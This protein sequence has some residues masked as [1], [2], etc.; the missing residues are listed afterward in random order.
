MLK[1]VARVIWEFWVFAMRRSLFVVLGFGS[2]TSLTAWLAI[3]A[4]LAG[5]KGIPEVVAR[6][7]WEVSGV[8]IRRFFERIASSLVAGL[9]G[10]S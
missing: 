2:S 3:T 1:V 5:R 7:A 6:V 4:S 10:L 9:C 8:A